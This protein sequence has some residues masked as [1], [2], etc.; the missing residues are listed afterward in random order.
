L[1]TLQWARAT[2]GQA[3]AMV[4]LAK[5]IEPFLEKLKTTISF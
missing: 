3:D 5:A 4:R 1:A 2:A